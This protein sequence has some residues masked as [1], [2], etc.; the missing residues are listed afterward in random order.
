MSAAKAT[1]I[2]ACGIA[3]LVAQ[4]QPSPQFEVASVRPSTTSVEQTG[5]VGL[6]FDNAQVRIDHLTL[7]DY[8]VIAYK[9]KISQVSG[10]DW[11][12]SDRF[13]ISATLP[14]GSKPEQVVEMLQ[15]LL[16]D[17]F[18][19]KIHR[20]KREFPVYALVLGKGPL[21]LKEV[22]PG[23]DDRKPADPV[24]IAAG[25]SESGVSVNLGNGAGWSFVPNR[26]EARK[27]T[28]DAFAGN[29]E[30]F[31]DRPIVDMTGLTSRYDFDFHINPEDYQ[32]MLIR[33]AVAAGVSLPPQALKLLEGSSSASLSDALAQVGLKLETRRAPLDVIVVDDGRRTPT[34][35]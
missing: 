4:A 3:A 16:E 34:E 7:K 1:M 15:A 11:I 25:G 6:H 8:I 26:F 9:T 35:N 20:E 27:L 19:L 28:M 2:A 13:D 22:P 18:Q 10:P 31:A 14:A 23:D 12:S 17:R 29:L 24:N 32:P 21:K 30:R 5:G 33:S